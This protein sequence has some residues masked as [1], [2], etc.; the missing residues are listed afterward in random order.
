MLP[1]PIAIQLH[2]LRL[3]FKKALPVA[4]QL[5]VAAVEIDAREHV[6]PGDLSDTGR[7][8]LRKM[9]ADL[10]LRVAAVAFP[11]RR[12]YNV[13]T[14]LDLRI[15]A[16]KEAMKLA[17]ALGANV[18]VNQVG[19][20]P[21][22]DSPEWG[23]MREA[24]ADLGAY[25]NH[26]G[27][28]LAAETGSEKGEDL[29]RLVEAL[30]EGALGVTFN[31]GNLIVNGFSAMDAVRALGRYVRYV[32]AR[33]AVR[34]LARGRGEEVPLGRGVADF[35]ALLAA[36]EDHGYRGYLC[37]ERERAENP[38]YEIGHAVQFLKS[39]N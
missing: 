23:T 10:N 18:V 16:T 25:G 32:H 3:P 12:G 39:L 22:T 4:A 6:R 13:A 14:E 33:D 19:R 27:A 17:H 28:T 8:Q 24:L 9:L 35:P 11:T 34:D 21:A 15:S 2:S 31:P 29:A 7:R 1:L 37:V 26:V 36:L 20:V 5:G 30:P 38:V